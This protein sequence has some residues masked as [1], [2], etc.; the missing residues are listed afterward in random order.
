MLFYWAIFSLGIAF[1]YLYLKAF[2]AKF[3]GKFSTNKHSTQTITILAAYEN[4]SIIDILDSH[5]DIAFDFPV[6][7]SYFTMDL[8]RQYPIFKI[9]YVEFSL[10][11]IFNRILHKMMNMVVVLKSIKY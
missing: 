2:Y 8:V 5:F 9:S 4:G 3:Q 11:F 6:L 7:F 10:L 1:E